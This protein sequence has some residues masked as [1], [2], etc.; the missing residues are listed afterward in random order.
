MNNNSKTEVLC[1]DI[2]GIFYPLGKTETGIGHPDTRTKALPG[3]LSSARQEKIRALKDEKARQQSL[4]AGLLLDYGLRKRGWREKEVRIGTGKNG[5]PYFPDIPELF[6]NL[7]HSENRI[8]AVFS[9]RPVGCDIQ[10]VKTGSS[11]IAD[12]FFT[13]E[14]AAFVRGGDCD[15]QDEMFT[16]LWVLKESYL[17][18]T[19]EGMSRELQSFC[20]LDDRRPSEAVFRVYDLGKYKAAV[21]IQTGAVE[22]EAEMIL[23]DLCF[24]PFQN[25]FD[26]V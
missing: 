12:R 22:D 2:S 20:V 7:S 14:E 16:E 6:F 19:G 21:C 24:C 9:D 4:A 13:K 15:H 25:L 11:R 17:K 1:T 26:V 8:L 10:I 3:C 5:K 23:P 18:M